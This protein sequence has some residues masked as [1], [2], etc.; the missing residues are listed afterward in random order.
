[1]SCSR[2][3]LLCGTLDGKWAFFIRISDAWDGFSGQGSVCT[4]KWK[5]LSSFALPMCGQLQI[6]STHSTMA[7][8]CFWIARMMGKEQRCPWKDEWSI[9][10]LLWAPR[11]L[12]AWE[13]ISLIV[14]EGKGAE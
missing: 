1:M 10:D 3:L 14:E 13:R 5:K 9:M 11:R 7:G 4:E 12:R 2:E 8:L 6:L